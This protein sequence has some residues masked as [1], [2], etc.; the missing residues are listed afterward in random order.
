MEEKTPPAT[1]LPA[2]RVGSCAGAC[3]VCLAAGSGVGVGSTMRRGPMRGSA[4]RMSTW[5]GN[6]AGSVLVA[7]GGRGGKE[8]DGPVRNAED[9]AVRLSSAKMHVMI[10]R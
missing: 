9:V 3:C 1:G 6:A 7:A 4:V 10:R 8:P 2:F 5:V